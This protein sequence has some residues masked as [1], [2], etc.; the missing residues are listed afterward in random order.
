MIILFARHMK[1]LKTVSATEIKEHCPA[2]LE[3]V[4]QTR[5][6]L[7]A[8]R[9]SKPVAEISPCVFPRWRFG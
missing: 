7:L 9:H 3:E 8:T 6:S 1:P 4:R 5:Q 2:L